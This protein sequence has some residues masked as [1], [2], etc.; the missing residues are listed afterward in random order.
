M[1]TEE[2]ADEE[3]G[4]IQD[5]RREQTMTWNIRTLRT[6]AGYLLNCPVMFHPGL[7]CIIGARGTCKSTVVETIRFV[8]DCDPARVTTM[9][10]PPKTEQG[11]VAPHEGLIHETLGA[12]TARCELAKEAEETDSLLVERDP[13]SPPRVF[14]DGIQQIDPADVLRRIEIYSQGDLQRIAE[15][16]SKRLALI[17]KPNEKRVAELAAQRAQITEQLTKLGV[18]I[19]KRRPE[20]EARRAKIKDLAALQSQL[21]KLEA[22][23]PVLSPELEVERK[24]YD[25]RRLI[26]ARVESAAQ[27]NERAATTARQLLAEMPA[28]REARDHAAGVSHAPAKAI[29]RAIEQLLRAVEMVEAAIIPE[30]T[31]AE[32]LSTLRKEFEHA[33]ARYHTLRKDQQQASDALRTE[34]TL[35]N[36]ISAMENVREELSRLEI[37]HQAD[38]DQRRALRARRDAIADELYALRI[39][40]IESINQEFGS[41]IV[42]TLQQ[43]VLSDGHRQLLTDLLQRSNLRT[44]VEVAKELAERIRPSDLVDIVESGDA[45]RLT[46]VLGR[47]LGQMTRLVS[48]LLDSAR[49]YELEAIVPEDGLEITMLVRGEARPLGQLSKGQMATALL[50]L[51]LREAPYPLLV[52]QPEDDL[53]NAF[54]SEKL[55]HRIRELS[56][57]RQLIFV[58]HNANIPVLGDAKQVIVM[59]MDGPRKARPARVGDVDQMK[60]DII[61]ILEGGRDAFR[62]RHVRYG[63]ALDGGPS[64]PP[65]PSNTRE[66]VG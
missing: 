53:D 50:P 18:E 51:I 56:S 3:S 2:N 39:G 57:R 23:R 32:H 33:S 40:Q 66:S 54:V 16:P 63:A 62:H 29:A 65:S 47:D 13:D 46:A 27:A 4:R 20:L 45:S 55:I 19:R 25:E 31:M 6:S 28:L 12:G 24:A 37:A 8:F 61:K 30:A 52:D 43:G 41:D 11:P 22:E 59:E 26:Y 5:K 17:D 14:R 49:L 64:A 34:E 44:Q 38:L 7:N 15:Q 35:R 10:T 58:T 36:T 9:L 42:L 48:H 60:D 1:S 21:K